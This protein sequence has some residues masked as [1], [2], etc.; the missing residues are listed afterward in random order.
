M[1][2]FYDFDGT[3]F[4]TYPAMVE[5]FATMASTFDVRVD[6]KQVYRQMRQGSLGHALKIFSKENGVDQVIVEKTFRHHESEILV[7]S[8]P[9][10][11]VDE[12]LS[13]VKQTGGRNYLLTH[14]NQAAIE[15]L[16]QFRLKELFT[17]FVT[18]DMTFPRKPDPAS[19]DYLIRRNDVDKKTAYMIGDRNLD[20]DAAHNAGIKGI[21]FDPDQII[22]VSSHPEFEATTFLEI[23]NYLLKN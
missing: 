4:D 14:R 17:D 1:D 12:L 8:R 11:Y 22:E 18:G 9:F 21:L 6:E 20:I 16:D 3:L 5:A 15:L 23:T 19:L 7:K 10:A 2:I 13:R